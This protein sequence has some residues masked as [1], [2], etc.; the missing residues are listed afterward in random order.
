MDMEDSSNGGR[1]NNLHISVE[2]ASVGYGHE[3][4]SGAGNGGRDPANS[5]G[6]MDMFHGGMTIGVGGICRLDNFFLL[7]PETSGA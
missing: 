7:A 3:A 4:E 5:S 2:D 6:W 1:P